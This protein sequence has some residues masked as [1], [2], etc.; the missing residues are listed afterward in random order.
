MINNTNKG[1]IRYIKTSMR[2]QALKLYPWAQH[3]IVADGG[4]YCFENKD[5]FLDFKRKLLNDITQTA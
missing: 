4:Y 5:D 1:R 3:T 2:T